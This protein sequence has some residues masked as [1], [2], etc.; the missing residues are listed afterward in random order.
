MKILLISAYFPP[1]TGS[2]ANL[3]YDLG[4]KLTQK[5]F[6]VS[7]LTSFPSYHVT[8]NI[9]GYNGQKMRREQVDGLSVIRIRVPQFPRYIP[10]MR[11][12]WQ[13]SMAYFFSRSIRNIE[14][15]DVALVY[16]PPL[17]L[18]FTG[19]SLSKLWNIPYILNVQDLFP[20]SAIDLNILKNR[21]LIKFFKLLERKIYKSANHIT[22]HSAGNRNYLVNTGVD[23]ENVTIMPNWVDTDYL[24]PGEKSNHF[25]RQHRL[26]DKFVV[27]FAGVIGYSQDVDVILEAAN[28]LTGHND[29]HF[30]IVGDGVEKDR[31]IIKAEKM[32]L[33][34]VTFLPMQP[35]DVYSQV[36]HTSDICLSTLNKEVKTPV[37]PS[38]ILSIMAVG[39]PLIACMDMQGDAPEIVKKA[40]CGFVF[41]AGSSKG[42]ADAIIQLYNNRELCDRYGKNGHDYCVEHFSLDIC[43]NKYTQLF[44]QFVK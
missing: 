14:K 44:K 29:I 1:D 3:F 10:A 2:A 16:S 21:L 15:H 19:A 36:L 8:G 22:V 41:P 9:D 37:V 17:P 40:K 42:L 27:S 35:R 20:Q 23:S 4:K 18:G 26:Q 5:G 43:T 30:L 13:F 31:L 28:Q 25:S 33:T 32:N 24:Q 38:K 11:A 34:N 39:K 12:L 6:N 7:V